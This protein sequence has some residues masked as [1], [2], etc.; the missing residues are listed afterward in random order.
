MRNYSKLQSEL[1]GFGEIWNGGYFEGDPLDPLAKSTYEEVGYISV[2]HATYLRCI[3][4][5]INRET[6]ALEIGPGRGA[7]TKTLLPSKEIYVMDALSAEHNGFFNYVGAVE[8]VKYLHV[9]DFG[10][11]ELPNNYFDYMFSFGTLCHVSFEGIEEYAQNLFDKLKPG[12]N[13]FWMIGDYAKYNEVV[14][15]LGM[16][17]IVRRLIPQR[18]P[19]KRWVGT[20]L[21]DYFFFRNS[22]LRPRTADIDH[23]P[24]PGRW[25]DA[26]A[27]RT[28]EMLE[29]FGY[30]ILD[31]DVGTCPRDPII[32]FRKPPL[33]T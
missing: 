30:E 6:V 31:Y 5:F 27:E 16:Y 13:C 25:Y 14:N 23:Q 12:A 1:S 33:Y 26:G 9:K 2:I 22:E 11:E 32:H 24:S 21:S 3:R 19:L 18:V 15:N 4:P 10:C 28:C 29:R 7:W 17:G 20:F 8:N